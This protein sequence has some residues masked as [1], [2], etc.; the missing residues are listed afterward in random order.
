MGRKWAQIG[1][2]QAQIGTEYAHYGQ[3]LMATDTKSAEKAKPPRVSVGEFVR[4]VRAEAAKIVWPTMSETVRMT[5]M[6]LIMA[7]LLS[8]FFLGVDKVLAT[9]VKFL[10]GLAG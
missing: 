3:D 5:I 7:T 8:L 1:P 9:T 10:L 4:Q 6:V 2:D